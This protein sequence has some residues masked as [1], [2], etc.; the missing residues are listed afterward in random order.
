MDLKSHPRHIALISAVLTLVAG[1]VW[2]TAP[3]KAAED[4][5]TMIP[6]SDG[7]ELA[8]Q[9]ILPDDGKRFPVLLNM[10]PYGPASYFSSY[11]DE[12]YAHVNVDIRGTGGSEGK[13][14][15]F[16]DREQQDVYDVV[17]WIARQKWSNGK[18]GMYGG[19]YQ[20]ITPLM[21]AS[22][23]P[24]HLEAIVPAV[25]LA[26]AYRDIVWHN[27]IFNANFVAQWTALQFGLGATGTAPTSD[28][29]SRP[30]QRLA[31]ESRL[32]PWDGPFYKERSVYTKFDDIKVPTLL[33]GG[34]FDGF[35]RGTLDVYRGI[36]SKHKRLVMAPCT[37]KGCGG[38]FDPASEYAADAD[39][40]GLED[41]VLAWM[42]HFL[43]GKDNDIEEGGAPVLY[44]DLGT[45]DWRGATSWPPPDVRLET[46][47]LS[48]EPSGSGQSL[49]DGSLVGRVPTTDDVE[50]R[51]VYDPSIGLTETFS[52]WGTVAASPHLRLDNRPDQTR[53]LTY[54]TQA[55]K[56]PLELAGPMELN[57]WGITTA[58][59]VDWVAKI[60]DVAP[61]GSTK[62]ITSGYVRAS[63][64]E[65]DAK[66]SRPGRPWLPNNHAAPV[67]A[68]MPLEYRIDIW[69]IAHT[70]RKGHRL[71]VTISSSDVPNH[72]PLAEAA[73]N[74][75]LH[76]RDYPS[77]LLVTVR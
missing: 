25:V 54:T 26:D 38:P 17:E 4:A 35:S 41:P 63:H 40:P 59:D 28:L 2:P 39:A 42:D 19:S 48:G 32:V 62:L 29:S 51:Y 5:T 12:G 9:I 68:G 36:A 49:N 71:R 23:Q 56:E 37:H 10:T 43:K 27:G 44:Y 52:K 6:V 21:G 76:S 65:W 53:S 64:R 20:G 8:A 14:C 58:S 69:D 47:Y 74:A 33:L 57:F 67:P 45:N 7:T 30:Q 13:L 24:P 55:A 72:E 22:K 75:V 70:I 66:R 15:L 60:T 50:D 11:T 3:S 18:V 46:F 31:A 1:F 34:W 77:R 61:D 73:V 16:C